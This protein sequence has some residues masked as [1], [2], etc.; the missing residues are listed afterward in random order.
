[1]DLES[2]AERY[3]ED[4]W[5]RLNEELKKAILRGYPNSGRV[6]C[7]GT[8]ILKQLAT[9]LLPPDHPAYRH[10]MECSPC[11]QEL[12]DIRAA[13][14]AVPV[15]ASQLPSVHARR[16]K[17]VWVSAGVVAVLICVA[18]AYYGLSRRGVAPST[19]LVA[20]NVDLQRWTVF[21]SDTPESPRPPL[22]FPRERLDLTFTLPVGSEDGEYDIQIASVPGGPALVSGHGTARLEDHNERL[23]AGLDASSLIPGNYSLDI[24]RLGAGPLHI[25]IRILS[26]TR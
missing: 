24:R 22:E 3:S 23:R 1:M 19:Q 16:S 2:M 15:P 25:P 7:P 12:M 4:E 14:P 20:L 21:R 9:R 8:E 6:G 5:R 11:Y 18:L 13:I 10:V 26:H 17:W